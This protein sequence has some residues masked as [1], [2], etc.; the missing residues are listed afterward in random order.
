MLDR[1]LAVKT[2]VNVTIVELQLHFI[3]L[4]LQECTELDHIRNLLKPFSVVTSEMSAEL[5]VHASKVC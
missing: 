3:P 1:Y 4:T 2:A 5:Y